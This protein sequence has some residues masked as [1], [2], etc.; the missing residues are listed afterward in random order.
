MKTDFALMRFLIVLLGCLCSAAGWAQTATEQAP[1]APPSGGFD[2]FEF[3][4]EGNTVLPALEIE[5][6]V[7]PHLGPNVGV[8][9]V[10][11][12]RDALER[13][14][15]DAGFLTVTVEVPEQRVTEGLVRLKVVE[16][17]VE[18]L[19]VS[20]AQYTLPSRMRA[21]MPSVA[22]GEVPNFNDV[23]DD[24]TELGRNP[25]LR[26]NPL[27]RPGARPGS[28]EVELA[29]DDRSPLHGSLEL[30]NK[31]SADTNAGRIEGAV[32][33]DNLW[34]RRHSI[35][36][37]YFVSP[38]NRDDVEVWGMNYAMPL[39]RATLAAFFAHSS[40]DVP[41]AFGTQSIGNGDTM[42]FRW[43]RPLPS[44]E[45]FFHSISL[46]ADYK[47]NAQDTVLADTFTVSQPIHYWT[48]AVQYNAGW[49]LSTGSL[50]LGSGINFGLD[51]LNRREI[52]CIG[53]E[54]DQFECRRPGAEPDFA[55]LRLNALYTVPFG[56][57][58]ISKTSFELQRASGPLV[59]TEQFS[60]GGQDSIRGY[61]EGERQADDALKLGA[62]ISTPAFARLLEVPV[63]GF[64]F[65]DWVLMELQEPLATQDDVFVM[66]SGG[67]GLRLGGGRGLSAE[68]A[69]AYAFHPGATGPGRTRDGDE[70]AVMRLKYEF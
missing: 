13:A 35:G 64:A 7:Y 19:K 52:D 61:L 17:R 41:T 20:G 1:S 24:L 9:A 34:Q 36:F 33:Y 10:N 59:N 68:L 60:A 15:H 38:E 55:V 48:M 28:L 11:A 62:E 21:Q 26:I 58:W 3:A 6:A 16:G 67:A 8:G 57:G 70:R 45:G 54:V 49:Q 27:L 39:G 31:R 37:N 40:S 46:G 69:L 47:D 53:V 2:V 66:A 23:Q 30:N 12:A 14:Y 63:T 50:R 29:M 43:I 51:A 44:R 25:D 22:Q 42:G 56:A 65:Y 5:R 18:R 4:V 32:R